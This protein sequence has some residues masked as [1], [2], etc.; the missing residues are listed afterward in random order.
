MLPNG[1]RYPLGVGAWIRPRNRSP[2]KPG[3]CLKNA[4]RTPSRVHAVLGVYLFG[5][6]LYS[7]MCFQT[8]LNTFF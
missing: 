4:A 6:I 2:P 7:L 5:L 3:K 1:L 8:V